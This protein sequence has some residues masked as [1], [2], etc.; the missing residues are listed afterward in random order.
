[1]ADLSEHIF[2]IKE[3][4]KQLLYEELL[5]TG[6]WT[7]E[8][9]RAQPFKFW[10]RRCECVIPEKGILKQRLEAWWQEWKDKIDDRGKPLFMEEAADVHA[11]Q[12]KLVESGAMSGRPLMLAVG[13]TVTT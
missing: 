2:I 5:A 13:A 4:S 8:G 12:I 6:K 9:L 1:M 10:R 3:D 11:N 7:A